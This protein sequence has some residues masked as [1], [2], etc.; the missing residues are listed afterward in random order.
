M[1]FTL[2]HDL[3]TAPGATPERTVFLLHGI[4]GSR[5]N[6]RT[7]GRAFAGRFPRWRLVAVD[8]RHHG[9]SRGAP[10]PHTVAACAADLVELAGIVG[11][12]EAVIGHSFGAKVALAYAARR[13]RGLAATWLLDGPPGVERDPQ[14]SEVGRMVGALAGLPGALATR[15]AVAQA[16]LAQGFSR[17]LAVWM[18]ANLEHDPAGGWR[19]HFDLR[20]VAALLEDYWQLDLWHVLEA[21]GL[22]AMH[23]LVGTRSDRFDPDTL[24]RCA[25]LD[26]AGVLKLHRLD[27][28]HW[29]H[30]DD[31]A[32]LL[33]ALAVTFG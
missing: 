23:V 20:G 22:G 5:R 28:G 12:P 16:L 13:P 31:P 32:G 15:D 24:A 30:V 10:P 25:A 19:W 1:A 11:A 9:G 2:A 8:L 27:A 18:A 26:R 17:G 6:W 14:H 33:A 29:V 3:V 7:F 4:F 21:G